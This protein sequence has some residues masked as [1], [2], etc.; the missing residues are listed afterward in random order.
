MTLWQLQDSF[1]E[2][3]R[4]LRL[5]ALVRSPSRPREGQAGL[6]RQGE[7]LL[8]TATLFACGGLFALAWLAP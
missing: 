5:R 8:L 2:E 4:I 6:A 7:G 3:A 1:D